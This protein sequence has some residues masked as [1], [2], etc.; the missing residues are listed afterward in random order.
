MRR[1]YDIIVV[2][3]GPGGS[4]AAKHAAERGMSVLLLEK[5][6]EIGVPVRC[7]E[8]VSLSEI[9]GIVPVEDHWIAQIVRGAKI[10]SPN[11]IIVEAYPDES[12]YILHRKLFDCDLAG[13]AARAGC[14]ILTK[15]YVHGLLKKNGV[16]Q[17]VQVSHLGKEY[18]ILCS[19][20]IGADGVE[21]R[22]GR[23]AELETRIPVEYMASCVQM[24]LSGIDIDP[25]IVQFYV[26]S[27]IAP[28]GYLWIFPKGPKTAN[29]GLGISG[30]YSRGR[31]PLL[32]LQN[33]IKNMFP[34]ASV[35][36]MVAGGVPLAPSLKHIIRDGL[37]LVGD[38]ARQVNPMSG[39]GI[40][41]AMIAGSIAGR[42]A[43]EAVK[44]GDISAKRLLSYPHEW[45]R[46]KG[47]HNAWSFKMKQVINRFPDE[48]LD[49]IAKMLLEIPPDKRTSFQIFKTALKKHP[50]LLLE[51]A[52]IFV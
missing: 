38:A 8:G 26:G 5:D 31:R 40:V 11:G 51:A 1:Q 52:K 20:V 41:N 29:V 32:Y 44:E 43:A 24:T 48:E 23:W 3:G 37:M 47:K 25:Q 35:L 18:S 27:D 16:V 9:K 30:G 42:V 33:F 13:M 10:I 39:G 46:T 14:E 4:W 28:G 49:R 7:A 15:A 17:G 6:R 50:R 21:S 34:K 45:N 22:V 12:G 36:T 19:I 2:G